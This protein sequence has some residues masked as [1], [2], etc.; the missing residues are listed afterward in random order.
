MQMTQERLQYDLMSY[1]VKFM[2]QTT[3]PLSE[4]DSGVYSQY[5]L[6]STYLIN[7]LNIKASV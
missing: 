7:S 1:S 5:L 3:S 6:Q 2:Q 4:G